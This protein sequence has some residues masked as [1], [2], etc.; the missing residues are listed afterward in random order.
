[1]NIRFKIIGMA[2]IIVVLSAIGSS[3]VVVDMLKAEKQFA[4]YADVC[5]PAT[6]MIMETNIVQQNILREIFDPK[7]ILDEQTF[8]NESQQSLTRL[9]EKWAQSI[10]HPN[11]IQAVENLLGKLQQQLPTILKNE[12]KQTFVTLSRELSATLDEV[13]NNYDIT[14]KLN[15]TKARNILHTSSFVGMLSLLVTAIVGPLLAWLLSKQI[16][17]PIHR[18]IDTLKDI[19]QGEGDLTQRIDENRKDELGELGH[20]FNHFI[21]NI[22]NVIRQAVNTTNDVATAA[23]EIAATSQQ[24]AGGMNDQARQASQISSAV[25]EM[26]ASTIE[27]ARQSHDAS[28]NAQLA[29]EYAANGSSVVQQSIDGMNSISLIVNDSATA[30]NELGKRS[31]QIGQIINVINDIADQTN[32]LALNAAIE[33]ARAGEHG[34]GFAVVADEVRKLAERTTTATEEVAKSI[35]DIQNQTRAAVDRISQGTQTV[36][37]GVH[38][39][40][41]ADQALKQIVTSATNVAGMIQSIASAA[42]EQSTSSEL[43]TQNINAINTVTQQSAQGTRQTAIAAE[44]LSQ[45]STQLKDLIGHFKVD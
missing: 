34:R 30:I 19:A 22:Q 14:R 39:A 23:H 32:L 8:I 21:S 43:I 42:Q 33:A 13:E 7:H 3:W 16:V 40:T 35:Q 24:M 15:A 11:Q 4:Y 6:D 36:D 12:N 37:H 10:H 5:W 25:E 9:S 2:V 27:V 44:Q 18:T 17:R 26:S 20:W 1:M 41:Q 29:G 45:R 31:E 28:E 38:L